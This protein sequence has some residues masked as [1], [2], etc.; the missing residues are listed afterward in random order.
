MC[1]TAIRQSPRRAVS[2][3][4]MASTACSAWVNRAAIASGI[5]PEAAQRRRRSIEPAVRGREPTDLLDLP[6]SVLDGS[7]T[8]AAL[9]PV[10]FWVCPARYPLAARVRASINPDRPSASTSVILPSP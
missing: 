6:T 1:P 10:G 2:A 5:R 4:T 3:A 7:P 8:S 9:V